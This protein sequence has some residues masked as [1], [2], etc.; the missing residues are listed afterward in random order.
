MGGAAP[1]VSANE[2]VFFND[3]LDGAGIERIDKLG[4]VLGLTPDQIAALAPDQVYFEAG[5]IILGGAGSDTIT[6]NGGDDILDGD[7]WLNVRIS[8][9]NTGERHREEI[10]TVDS[11]KHV[12]AAGER[13]SEGQAIDPN[14]VGKSLFELLVDR[15]VKPA[16]MQIVREIN[17]DNSTTDVDTAVFNDIQT[18][19]TITRGAGGALTVRHIT[20]TDPAVDDG[21]DTLRNFEQLQFADG[22]VPVALIL[23]RPFDSLNIDFAD[24]DVG[25]L[26]ATLVNP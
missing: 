1:T 8:I 9:K 15:V 11:L 25:T 23:D 12:F 13:N 4:E 21:T 20:L 18:N 5:N 10:A 26:R 14:W 22:T 17:T 6:G 3:G 19:Y 2:N 24:P 7:R 16:Q